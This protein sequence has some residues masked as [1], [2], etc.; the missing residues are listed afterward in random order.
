VIC[1][2]REKVHPATHF[3]GRWA[4]KEAFFKALPLSCQSTASWKSIEILGM[5]GSG[6]PIV[7]VCSVALQKALL[8]EDFSAT[9]ISKS[10]ER[11]YCIAFSLM[12]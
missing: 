5:D 2:C 11:D 8:K 4:A 3:A 9:H 10:H 12:E 7:H 1:Y 6:K